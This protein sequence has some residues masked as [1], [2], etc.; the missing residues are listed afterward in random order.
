MV[1][2]RCS[3]YSVSPL[4]P[5][6]RLDTWALVRP[7]DLARSGEQSGRTE[8][9]SCLSGDLKAGII[10]IIVIAVSI[11]LSPVTLVQAKLA[12]CQAECE[13]TAID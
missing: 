8:D 11:H 7:L 1:Y 9:T 12:V 6:E 10:I 2:L 3:K 5:L 4:E 13:A